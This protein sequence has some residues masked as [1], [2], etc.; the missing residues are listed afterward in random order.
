M[1][2]EKIVI[3]TDSLPSNSNASKKKKVAP[4][5]DPKSVKV[6]KATT[7]KK[8][9]EAFIQNDIK[10]VRK[11]VIDEV[12]IPGIKTSILKAVT[13]GLKMIFF[14]DSTVSSDISTTNR[15]G[16]TRISYNKVGSRVENEGSAY[17]SWVYDEL[18]FDNEDKAKDV[19]NSMMD[20]ISQYQTVSVADYYELAGYHS[21]YT[22]N[23]YGWTDLSRAKV[24]QN[25]D[26]CRWIIKL[27]KAFPLT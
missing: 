6:K 27:P 16:V 8:M 19:L 24:L 20:I 9:K 18:S 14:K 2:D 12:I 25:I 11:K 3:K 21:P 23:N 22:T 1:S 5:V 15:S 13:N 7:G 17:S 26:D 10:Y 4:V